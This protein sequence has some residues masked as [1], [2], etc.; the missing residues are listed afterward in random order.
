MFSRASVAKMKSKKSKSPKSAA[1]HQAIDSCDG[2]TPAGIRAAIRKSVCQPRC[3]SASL[4]I[5]LGALSIESRP[6]KAPTFVVTLSINV[7][8]FLSFFSV[9]IGLLLVKTPDLVNRNRCV[10]GSRIMFLLFLPAARSRHCL[11][12]RFPLVSPFRCL[13]LFPPSSSSSNLALAAAYSRSA[14]ETKNNRT[15]SIQSFCT[16]HVCASLLSANLN[17]RPVVVL[18]CALR[19]SID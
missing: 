10:A 15:G 2:L 11:L 4:L 14:A 9:I 3:S 16:M 18:R 6:Q 8:Y 5:S 19:R 7:H 13:S 17:K 1:E 12:S